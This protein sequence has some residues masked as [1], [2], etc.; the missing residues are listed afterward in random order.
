MIWL[1]CALW[2]EEKS[3]QLAELASTCLATV[4][5]AVQTMTAASPVLSLKNEELE[6]Q[7]ATAKQFM[8]VVRGADRGLISAERW[9]AQCAPDDM[10]ILDARNAVAQS[11][12]QTRT[13][14]TGATARVRASLDLAELH[15]YTQRTKRRIHR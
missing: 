15:R 3:P 11:K 2:R 7:E 8:D 4:A 12:A 1:A 5:E 13:V 9:S 6:G 10:T 14:I